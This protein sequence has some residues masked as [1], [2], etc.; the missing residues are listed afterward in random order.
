MKT[1]NRVAFAVLM[2]CCCIAA[3]LVAGMTGCANREHVTPLPAPALAP[4][5]DEPISRSYAESPAMAD[6]ERRAVHRPRPDY[7][8]SADEVWIISRC[9][10]ERP[11][12]VTDSE[13]PG[14]GE[15]VV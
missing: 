11:H 6:I 1:N 10:E 4:S 7:S 15:L 5:A 2:F 12:T 3:A 8:F 9:P 13:E 14:T